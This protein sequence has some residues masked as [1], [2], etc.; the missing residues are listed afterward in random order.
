MMGID[1]LRR[2]L[3]ARF[4][5]VLIAMPLL[6]ALFSA[7]GIGGGYLVGVV[8]IGVDSGAF[9]SQMQSGVDLASDI[10]SGV[11]KSVVFGWVCGATAL[12]TG[13]TARAT[14]EGVSEATT[15]GVVAS[16]LA[17]LGSDFLLTALFFGS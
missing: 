6:A 2:V 13:W 5:A 7:V 4:A 16:S 12:Y 1:P 3:A 11:F 8:L 14:P 15:R 10:G 17:V 9:W